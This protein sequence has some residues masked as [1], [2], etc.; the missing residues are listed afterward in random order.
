M[1]VGILT[2]HFSENY[3]A[4]FQAYALREWFIGRGLT[5][6]F[7]NYHPSY[8]EQGGSLDQPWKLSLWR[9][10][11]TILY[12][13]Q[14]YLRRKFFGDKAQRER[15]EGFRRNVLGATGPRLKRSQDLAP[16]MARYNMLFCGSDQIWNPSI[17]RGLDP[18]YFLDIP[19]A[20]H[21]RKVAYAPSFGRCAIEPEYNAELAVLVG[22]LDGVSVRETTGLDVLDAAGIA[23]EC[24][25]VVPDPTVLLGSFDK[26]LGDDV[27][28]DDSVFCY[29]LRTDEVIRNVATQS[30]RSSGLMR[31]AI[32]KMAR[33]SLLNFNATHLKERP[34]HD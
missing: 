25:C 22:K 8:V 33:N 26:L 31:C 18:V 3:G 5:A 24:A 20:D 15:F 28:P 29:A 14:A 17:Q 16:E 2:Y 34:T 4:L 13:K 9:K 6:E 23:R 12:M 30:T 27:T 32:P 21:A 19:G 1:K 11:A 10:N 7:V